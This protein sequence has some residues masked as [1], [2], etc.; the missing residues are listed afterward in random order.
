M[1]T[2]NPT[3]ALAALGLLL[4]NCP[5]DAGPPAEPSPVDRALPFGVPMVVVPS[6]ADDIHRAADT[7]TDE[8]FADWPT[9]WPVEVDEAD[10]EL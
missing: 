9:E 10:L 7:M 3:P 2:H 5:D 1:P 8:D 4:L 6:H